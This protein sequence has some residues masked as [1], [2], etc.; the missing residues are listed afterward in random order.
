MESLLKELEKGPNSFL[1]GLLPP[2]DNLVDALKHLMRVSKYFGDCNPHNEGFD[3][4]MPPQKYYRVLASHLYSTKIKYPKEKEQEIQAEKFPIE[5]SMRAPIE[6]TVEDVQISPDL[7]VAWKRRHPDSFDL[8][9]PSNKTFFILRSLAIH[10]NNEMQDVVKDFTQEREKLE[11]VLDFE[12]I[13]LVLEKKATKKRELFK[14][15]KLYGR[16]LQVCIGELK[17]QLKEVWQ[18]SEK[19][20]LMDK[21]ENIQPWLRKCFFILESFSEN[22]SESWES[23]ETFGKKIQDQENF[24]HALEILILSCE[25]FFSE[26]FFQ[27][28]IFSST[29][30]FLKNFKY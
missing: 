9:E 29:E 14:T 17:A 26:D 5:K 3:E 11:A 13:N 15:L 4:M 16:E 12:S 24:F 25:N 7:F 6:A 18:H 8:V 28:K 22:F 10:L 1:Q 2:G 20:R 19:L 27:M 21:N 30:K 23:W